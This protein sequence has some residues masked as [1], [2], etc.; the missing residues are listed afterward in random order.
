MMSDRALLAEQKFDD[1]FNC[2]QS[3][4]FAFQDI[5]PTDGDLLLRFASGFGAGMAR[6]EEVCGAVSGG[7]LVLGARH[8]SDDTGKN[9]KETAYT[10]VNALM[11]GFAK[12]QGSYI[13]RQL[14][15]GIDLKTEAGQQAMKDGQFRNSVCKVCVKKSVSLVQELL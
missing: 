4:V 14:L 10:K 13:C 12:S 2:A 3:V 7:I 9:A 6:N 5:L 15:H 8:G 1:G 11:D